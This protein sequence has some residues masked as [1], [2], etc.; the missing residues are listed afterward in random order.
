MLTT[1]K[2]LRADYYAFAKQSSEYAS[3]SP[4]V[5]KYYTKFHMFMLYDMLYVYDLQPVTS[6]IVCYS[7]ENMATTLPYLLEC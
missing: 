3:I 1:I 2:D 7:H 6:N 5:L 4:R